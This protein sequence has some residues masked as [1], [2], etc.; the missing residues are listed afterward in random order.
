MVGLRSF[1][2]ISLVVSIPLDDLPSS[3]RK[4]PPGHLPE[5]IGKNR[6]LKYRGDQEGP[7][8]I[9]L[10]ARRVQ[11]KRDHSTFNSRREHASSLAFMLRGND[12]HKPRLI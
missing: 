4:G 8:L 1:L 7:G 3:W 10:K 9:Y 12:C 2:M 11:N 5:L 6:Q